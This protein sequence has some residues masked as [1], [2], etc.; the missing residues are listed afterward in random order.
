M[1]RYRIPH[2]RYDIAVGWD[3]PLNTFYGII[4]DTQTVD[5]ERALLWLG[6]G[7]NQYPDVKDFCLQLGLAIEQ[8]GLTGMCFPPG[9]PAQLA[10]DQQREGI[11]RERPAHLLQVI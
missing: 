1:S 10:L 4:V 11:G 3:P 7:W 6:D 5:E 9:L 2:A 8:L